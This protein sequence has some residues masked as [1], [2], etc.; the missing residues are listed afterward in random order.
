MHA[1]KI[2]TC[3]YCGRRQTLKPTARGGHELAR[4]ADE[5]TLLEVLESLEGSLAP[6]ECVNEAP[7]SEA[8]NLCG[9]QWVW[10]DI[11]AELHK[12]LPDM[13]LPDPL[14][15]TPVSPT[16]F[17]FTRRDSLGVAVRDIPTLL[18]ETVEW[19]KSGPFAEKHAA[20]P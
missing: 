19:I 7:G 6:M 3:C 5:V 12:I 1:T 14:T 4:P 13:K 20:K 18:R 9:Q 2:A 11:Y 10:Q 15:E 16:G 17:D 8:G